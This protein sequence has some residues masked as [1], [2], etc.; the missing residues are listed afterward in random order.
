MAPAPPLPLP[1]SPWPRQ[2]FEDMFRVDIQGLRA[3][4]VVAVVLFHA[5]PWLVPGGYVGVDIFFVI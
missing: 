2:G 1:G 5:W 3:I 4:A